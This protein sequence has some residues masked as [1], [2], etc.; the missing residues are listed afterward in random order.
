MLFRS[1]RDG[2]GKPLNQFTFLG[3]RSIRAVQLA[4]G[5]PG[6]KIWMSEVGWS[7]ST[8]TCGRGGGKGAGPGGV[9]A[10]NQ[11][12]FLTQAY[13]CMAPDDY[14]VMAAWFTFY[15]SRQYP[16]DEIHDLAQN[17]RRIGLGVM[18]WADM[19]VRLGVPYDSQDGVDL[20]RKV[21]EFVNEESRIASEKLAETRGVFPAW[22]KSI[23]GPDETCARRADGSR[24]RPM[25]M[26]RNCK[27]GRAHV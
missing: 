20:A 16:L 10:E 11:A 4:N 2:P 18:G 13:G 25:R 19:L 9:G 24:V 6:P 5:D 1:L 17:I 7:S 27:I 22:E 8:E 23:W 15:D 26:L 21:M 3:Y 14:L 12:K